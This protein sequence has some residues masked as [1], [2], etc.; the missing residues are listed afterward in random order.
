LTASLSSTGLLSIDGSGRNDQII[1]RQVNNMI[2]IDGTKIQVGSSLAASVAAAK[3]QKILVQASGGNDL[4]RLDSQD[5]GGQALVKPAVIWAGN[6]PE[7]ILA[8]NGP[9]TVHGGNGGDTIHGGS[10]NDVLYG[11]AGNDVIYAGNGK[12]TA[13]YGEGGN[14]ILY[15]GTGNDSLYGGTGNDSLYGGPGN[16]YLDGGAGL[17]LLKGGG[18]FNTYRDE[19][20]L[21]TPLIE[22]PPPVIS[23]VHQDQS[24]TCQTLAAMASAVQAGIDFR[25]HIT[26]QG[27][28]IFDVR[29]WKGGKLVTVRVTFDGSWNDNDPMPP[30]DAEGRALPEFWTTL[31]QRARLQLMGVDTSK[32]MTAAQWDQAN[33]NSNYLLYSVGNAIYTLTGKRT[34]MEVVRTITPQ[35]LKAVLDQRGIAVASTYRDPS[36]IDSRT[37]LTP[38]HAYSVVK[39]FREG[40][41]W[42]V[43]LYNPFGVDG[44][45][46]PLDGKNDGF[47][48]INWAQFYNNFEYVNVA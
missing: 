22:P 10:G 38:N 26:Y 2:S 15:G 24:P 23:D 7:K 3:V 27:K 19:F 6:G 48:T 28:H 21:A 40:N 46:P 35:S 41:T 8:D 29:L 37:N 45:G 33:K 9:A 13:A 39:V 17:N 18:G 20:N 34:K 47:I 5:Y 42:K 36:R 30:T 32:R 31:L 12:A 4:I 43:K 25:K 14:D 11:G 1:V 16:D 44:N